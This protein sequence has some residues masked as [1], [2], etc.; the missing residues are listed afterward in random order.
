MLYI[1]GP[2]RGIAEFNFPAFDAAWKRLLRAGYW[3]V[4]PAD[5]DREVGFDATGMT[6]NEDLSAVG[7]DLPTALLWD[8]EM[9]ARGDGVALLDG[10]E[11]SLGAQAEVAVARALGVP[12]ATVAEWEAKADEPEA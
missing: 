11:G 7:F 8:L 1:A 10:W 6:G 5:H 9:V 12:V 2:M 3:P 4:S